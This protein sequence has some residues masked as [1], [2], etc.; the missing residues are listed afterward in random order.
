[1]GYF[2][3]NEHLFTI[4]SGDFE[5]TECARQDIP[6]QFERVVCPNARKMIF[7]KIFSKM[8]ISKPL[9]PLYACHHRDIGA[10][11]ESLSRMGKGL[12]STLIYS[13]PARLF[14]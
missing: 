5:R 12:F 13:P 4:Y 6:A 14:A 1:M 10:K 8:P 2:Y 7:E 11:K 9:L 3:T